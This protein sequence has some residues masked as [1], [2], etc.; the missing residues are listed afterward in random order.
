SRSAL[1]SF[2]SSRTQHY[3]ILALV[4]LDVLGI[5]ADI[6]ITLYQCEQQKSKPHSGKDIWDSV[7]DGLG[8]AGLVFS[9]L[10]MVELA[11]SICAFGWA[12][13]GSSW[14]HCFDATVIVASFVIDVVL[15]GV[16]EE[17]ASLVVI[18]RL[19]RF[20][21]IVEE[22]SVGAEEQ[23]EG[24]EM[25][26]EQLEAENGDLKRELKRRKGT[27]DEEEGIQRG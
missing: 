9:C 17:V 11:L 10:F 27:L 4:A 22:F 14:F 1:Q 19:W 12:Y 25:R 15:K 8:I 26:I 5:L 3:T 6:F 23:L 20:F 24:L 13:F 2:L 18:L 7:R 21:K 16:V